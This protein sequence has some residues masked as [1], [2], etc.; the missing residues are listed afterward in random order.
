MLILHL[1]EHKLKSAWNVFFG[2]SF[3]SR[4][5]VK[6]IQTG[7]L[8]AFKGLSALMADDEDVYYRKGQ[9]NLSHTCFALSFLTKTTYMCCYFF[10]TERLAFFLLFHIYQQLSVNSLCATEDALEHWSFCFC[11]ANITRTSFLSV[12]VTTIMTKNP[13]NKQTTPKRK[14]N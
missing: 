9:G 12:V 6:Y 5:P 7:L 8:S 10:N 11:L 13:K 14:Q 3:I 2:R 1:H 4:S